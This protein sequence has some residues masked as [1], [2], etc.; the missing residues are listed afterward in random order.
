[1]RVEV[2]K[3]VK[4][5]MLVFLVCVVVLT[6]SSA[7]KMQTVCFSETLVSTYD[8][9]QRFDPDEQHREV[10]HFI[11]KRLHMLVLKLCAFKNTTFYD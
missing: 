9:T 11:S 7:L 8:S 2:I 10:G 1:M 6:P 4:M 5:S 3:A